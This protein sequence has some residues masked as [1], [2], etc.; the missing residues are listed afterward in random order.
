MKKFFKKSFLFLMT[1]CFSILALVG[2]ASFLPVYAITSSYD[3][4]KTTYNTTYDF[5]L[6]LY[7]AVLA[8]AKQLNCNQNTKGFDL[9]LFTEDYRT[10]S[11]Y[12]KDVDDYYKTHDTFYYTNVAARDVVVAD[13][14]QGILN[15]TTGENAKYENLKTAKPIK[16]INGLNEMGLGGYISTIYLDDNALEDITEDDLEFMSNLKVLS[17]QNNNLKTVKLN[18]SITK[19]EALNLCGNRIEKLSNVSFHSTKVESL[20]LSFNNILDATAGEIEELNN[21]LVG[22]NNAFLAV[23][24]IYVEDSIIAGQK[25][26]VYNEP[27]ALIENINVRIS[28]SQNSECYD[29]FGQNIIY[30]DETRG[31][32]QIETFF[33]PAGKLRVDFYSGNYV[34]NKTNFNVLNDYENLANKFGSCEISVALP[35]LNV[36]LKVD[37]KVVESTSQDKNITVEF[38]VENSENITNLSAVLTKS[39]IYSSTNGTYDETPSSTVVLDTN[40]TYNCS[41][42]VS[43]DGINSKEIS[44]S[45]TRRDLVGIVWGVIIVVS[46]IILCGAAYFIVK[47]YREG[48]TVAPL[49]EKEI[50]A[51]KKRRDRKIGIEKQ[52]F[53]KGFNKPKHDLVFEP[54]AQEDEISGNLNSADENVGA[55]YGEHEKDDESNRY[56]SGYYVNNSFDKYDEQNYSNSFEDENTEESSDEDNDDSDDEQYEYDD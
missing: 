32:N 53:I 12:Y 47:W 26:C 29:E 42:Y 27:G 14:E 37:G 38:V 4:T 8:V 11:T 10:E 50:Y 31:L 6:T 46:I 54:D 45:V 17:V 23:Q 30:Q 7:E 44:V 15:L 3:V 1:L 20:D 33:I 9:D 2:G 40:G 36:V 51:L 49:T 56:S 21:K 55:H 24:G 34:I 18:S 19:L 39:K 43:F 35:K 22:S 16:S 52:V 28:Y 25:A 48:A 5:D 13:L 41:A